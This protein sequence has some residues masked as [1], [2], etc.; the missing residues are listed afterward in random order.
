MV[1]KLFVI[2]GVVMLSGFVI[3]YGIHNNNVEL[4]DDYL[5]ELNLPLNS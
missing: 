5:S 3:S 4:P 2:F 1:G